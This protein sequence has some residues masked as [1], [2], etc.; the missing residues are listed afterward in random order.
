MNE[1]GAP[2]PVRFA[3]RYPENLSRILNFPLGIGTLIKAILAIPSIIIW[4]V[5]FIVA[6]ILNFIALFAILFTGH[7]P[8]GFF[9]LMVG[10]FRMQGRVYAY[11]LSLT[12]EYP[13]FS[14]SAGPNDA[15]QFQVDYPESLNRLLNFPILG[16]YIK[17]ILCIPQLVVLIVGLIVAYVFFF[18]GQ[19]VVLFT[20]KFPEGMFRFMVGTLQLGM[21]VSAY[22]YSLTDRY[23]PITLSPDSQHILEPGLRV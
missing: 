12:D 16:L 10:A 20:G 23:P 19:F 11:L 6:L 13:G 3:V 22:I 2:Y 7:Y 14:P 21:R 9:N 17:S 8:Q 5:I 1:A 18:I 4:Y 15:A